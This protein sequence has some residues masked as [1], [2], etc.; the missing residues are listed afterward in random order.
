MSQ[1]HGAGNELVSQNSTT[2]TKVIE[3]GV[4]HLSRGRLR[5]SVLREGQPVECANGECDLSGRERG[6]KESSAPTSIRPPSIVASRGML[7]LPR[8]WVPLS[9]RAGS[10]SSSLTILV[11]FKK[12]VKKTKMVYCRKPEVRQIEISSISGFRIRNVFGEGASVLGYPQLDIAA[13]SVVGSL[14]APTR[15]LCQT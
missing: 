15:E 12:K 11:F 10:G 8:S 14:L 9:P 5:E 7:T 13:R 3:L 4:I 6:K 2:V 1:Q